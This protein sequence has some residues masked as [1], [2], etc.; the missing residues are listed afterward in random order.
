MQTEL[1]A[2]HLQGSVPGARVGVKSCLLG[3]SWLAKETPEFFDKLMGSAPTTPDPNTSAK[4]SRYKW[5]ACRDTN[6]WCID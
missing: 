5:E 3:A 2:C 4:V 1:F 6:W